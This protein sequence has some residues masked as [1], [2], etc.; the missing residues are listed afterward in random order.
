VADGEDAGQT[1]ITLDV[2]P[3]AVRILVPA[4]PAQ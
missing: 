3:E 4:D 2:L 1:P